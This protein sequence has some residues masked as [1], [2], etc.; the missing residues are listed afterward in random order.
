[1]R[2]EACAIAAVIGADGT[3]LNASAVESARCC[4]HA[5]GSIVAKK[6]FIGCSA[7]IAGLRQI[8]IARTWQSSIAGIPAKTRAKAVGLMGKAG[9]WS[10]RASSGRRK[11]TRSCRRKAP[12]LQNSISTGVMRKP[13]QSAAAEYHRWQ[14]WRCIWQPRLRAQTGPQAAAIGS[15]PTRRCGSAAGATHSRHRLRHRTRQSRRPARGFGAAGFSNETP[16]PPLGAPAVRGPW[17]LRSSCKKQSRG[18]PTSGVIQTLQQ[19]H[20]DVRQAVGINGCKR[21]RVRIVRLA[22]VRLPPVHA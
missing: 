13:D 3:A 15:T 17:C 10:R 18:L 5:A 12:A 21:H 2:V 9:S 6:N 1:M 8:S 19:N 20:A 4:G 7:S 16:L 22:G 14:I 11:T